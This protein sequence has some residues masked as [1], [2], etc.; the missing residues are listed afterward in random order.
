VKSTASGAGPEAGSAPACTDGGRLPGG[1]VAV[2]V[3]V[4]LSDAPSGSLTVS[5]TS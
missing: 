5:V 2:I 1:S 4:A 3:I